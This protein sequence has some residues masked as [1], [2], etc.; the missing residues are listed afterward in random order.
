[1]KAKP[2]IKLAT[3]VHCD[4]PSGLLNPIEEIVPVLKE[5]GVISIVDAVA[6]IAG[7]PV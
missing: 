3:L 6:S 4:T 2:D 5:H 7:D 1:M